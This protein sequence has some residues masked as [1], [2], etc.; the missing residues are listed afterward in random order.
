MSREV[1]VGW[2][3]TPFSDIASDV[4]SRNRSRDEIP[5]LSVTKYDGFVPSEEYFK[6][7][8][9]SA[10]T[11]NYKIVRK[12]QFAYATIHLDEGSVDRLTRFDVG[13][14]SPMYT[15]FEI[16]ER[17]ADPDF[18]L[19]LFKFCATNGQFDALGN[20][21]V[22]RRKSISFST[23]GKLS[24]PLP[25]LHEQ[26]RIA[27][28]LSSIDEAIAATR[29]VIEQTRKVKQGVLERLLTKGIGHTRFK[30]TE[31]GELP[32]GWEIK[33]V[34]E[35]CVL[36]NGNGFRPP[37]WSDKGLP[38]IRIQ[39]LNGSKNFNYFDG[40][41]LDK[42]LINPGDLLFA[43][44][45]VRGVSFGPTIWPGPLGVLNQHIFKISCREDVDKRWLFQT[46]KLITFKIEAKAHGFKDSLLHVHKKEIT[47][48]SVAVPPF[49]EQMG[50]STKAAELQVAEDLNQ[51]S[52]DR[53]QSLKSALMS[54][55]LT[56]RKRVTDA[57][58]MAAE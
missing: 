53:L 27:E 42:W 37:D 4:S 16:D 56:G 45:G 15:V 25:P 18:I 20:G 43:W 35:L 48:Q 54:D 49:A 1:A 30:Q 9:F 33:P 34:D 21:G 44:A 19:R 55:L 38:I 23:L 22:N 11:E 40:T 2:R 6:K 3:L 7:K 58:P 46:L 41:P 12:G 10:D 50:I 28:I 32:E 17:Q 52:L 36:S 31:I 39:N 24:I 14:I 51:A 29:A 5:V 13:L 57:L 8:V 47:G 26:R